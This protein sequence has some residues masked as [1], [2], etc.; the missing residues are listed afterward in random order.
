MEIVV[1]MGNGIGSVIGVNMEI[2]IGHGMEIG[3][4]I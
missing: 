3:I 4:W 1:V 2:M